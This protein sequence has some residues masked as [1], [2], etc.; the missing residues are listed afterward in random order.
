MIRLIYI[1]CFFFAL[2]LQIKVGKAQYNQLNETQIDRL[3]NDTV[4]IKKLLYLGDKYCATN[5]QKAL[6]YLQESLYLA[7]RLD[8]QTGI[9]W[10]YLWMGRVYYYKDEYNLARTSL[11]K[12]RHIL[13]GLADDFGWAFYYFA[14]GSISHLQGDQVNALSEFQQV[15]YF[16]RLAGSKLYESA[17]NMS[18]GTI[19]H[20]RKE[21]DEAMQYFQTSLILK[22]EIDDQKG[23]ANIYTALGRLFADNKQY[24]SAR[25]YYNKGHE[26]RLQ[27]NDPR[28]IANSLVAIAKLEAEVGNYEE[29]KDK[30]LEALSIYKNLNEKTGICMVKTSLAYALN[31]IGDRALAMEYMLQATDEA[32]RMKNPGLLL[33]AYKTEA[34]MRSVNGQYDQA[35]QL[36]V[37]AGIL[38][39]SLNSANREDIIQE[40]EARYQLEQKNT[41]IDILS[42]RNSTQQKNIIL[43]SV[44]IGALALILLLLAVLLRLKA[45]AHQRQKKLLEQEKTIFEQ[46]EKIKQK[47]MLLL[48]ES[49]ESKNRELATK[50]IEMLRVNETIGE[51]I[52]KLES[53]CKV[54]AGDPRISAHIKEIAQELENQTNT[55]TWKEFDKIFKNIHTEFYD[56]LLKACPSLTASEI[57]IAALLKLNLS[58]KEIAAITYK[59]EE[60]I[61]STRYRLRKKLNLSGD[62]KLIPYLMKL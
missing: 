10:S 60:G 62:K 55:N 46:E 11:N 52:N 14:M 1:G 12:A 49:V 20:N 58:T 36:A 41:E 28:A 22:I 44:S 48:H 37:K 57:K 32:R 61:K 38:Q 4:K 42:N 7:N 8:Y 23:I 9:A 39:D 3:P 33:K 5:N 16:S 51:V 40:M 47:E 18:L 59:S 13:E 56:N 26:I 31:G 21:F 30:L 45:K 25:M 19:H 54:H 29:S 2:C 53:M 50:A 35:Y 15:V 43:L 24:D 17:G 34:R 6:Y 27:R